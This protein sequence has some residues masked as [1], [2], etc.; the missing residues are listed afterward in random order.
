MIADL[1]VITSEPRLVE[2]A[3]P[4]KGQ[5]R[6]LARL[7]GRVDVHF[8]RLPRLSLARLVVW[9]LAACV[10]SSAV[11]GVETTANSRISRHQARTLRGGLHGQERLAGEDW[12]RRLTS[13]APDLRGTPDPEVAVQAVAVTARSFAPLP[14]VQSSDRSPARCRST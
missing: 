2:L 12:T 13:I 5:S 11:S 1:P 14:H 10:A 3:F 6:R 7:R 8:M 9:V 4:L